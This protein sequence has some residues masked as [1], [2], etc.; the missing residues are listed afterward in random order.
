MT[1]KGVKS[2]PKEQPHLTKKKKTDPF[3]SIWNCLF[4]GKW[5]PL[6]RVTFDPFPGHEKI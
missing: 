6:F 4:L 1:W 2:C 3:S 5:V